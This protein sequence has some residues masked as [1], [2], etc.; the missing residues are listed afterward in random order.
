MSL[1]A[2]LGTLEIG[3][4]YGL[5]AIGVYLTFRILDFP[6]LT[7]DGSFTLGAA[8][9]ATLIVAGQNPYLATLCGTLA[10]SCAGLVTAWL[11][12][13]FN[14]LHL[15]ASILTMTALY[16]I[17]LRV[18]GKPNVALIMEPT[19]L[20]PFEGIL[21]DMY[22]KVIFVAVCA[23]VGGLLVAWF[24]RTQYGLAMRAVGSNKR[25]AQAN[26]IVV[27]E[28][29]Y[30]GLALSNGLVGLAGALFAQTNGFAD[31]TMGIG[32]I[33]VGL[34]AVIIGESLL[35]SRSMLVIVMSCIVGSVL[36]RFA[37]SMALNA[38]FLGFQAS[39]LNLITAVLVALALVFP[40][41]R[42]EWKAKRAIKEQI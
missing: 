21:P 32:T 40:K 37:V 22:M 7:V 14:I 2:F 41:L 35:A 23:I 1:Y 3:L 24:L 11:N 26:G 13:R 12:L 18:M 20:S 25:M 17:N 19:V 5:V 10:A 39:D 29:V 28:K 36:Y 9:A 34:A 4:I 30:V 38:D 16:T 33:V 31:S 42:N 15:L 8:V 27:T 6:D